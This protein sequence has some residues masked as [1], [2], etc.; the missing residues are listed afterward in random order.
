MALFANYRFP[1]I[2]GGPIKFLHKSPKGT[3]LDTLGD[4]AIFTK[5]WVPGYRQSHLALFAKY[6]FP[7]ILVAILNFLRKSQMCTYHGY[8]AR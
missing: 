7:A 2:F 3:I 1:T 4:R 8:A 5:Y 6:N